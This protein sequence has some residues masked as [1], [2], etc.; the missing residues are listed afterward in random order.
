MASPHPYDDPICNPLACAMGRFNAVLAGHLLMF[1]AAIKQRPGGI[2]AR[3]LLFSLFLAGFLLP[4][5]L[6]VAWENRDLEERLEQDLADRMRAFGALA[7]HAFDTGAPATPS[8]AADIL[9]HVQEMGR[10][11]G[12]A[13]PEHIEFEIRPSVRPDDLGAVAGASQR[14]LM[15]TAVEDLRV[16]LPEDWQPFGRLLWRQAH[17]RMSLP[18]ADSVLG[19]GLLIEVSAAT[20]VEELQRT[21]LH[22]LMILLIIT[23]LAIVLADR[24][25]VLLIRPLQQL[26]EATG[27]LPARII[28]GETVAIASLGLLAEGRALNDAFGVMAK[29]FAESFATLERQR[30]TQTRLRSIRDL[31]AQMLGALM[32]SGED[33]R[34][35]AERL[36]TLLD[37]LLPAYRCSVLRPEVHAALVHFSGVRLGAVE[38]A[39]LE[40]RLSEQDRNGTPGTDAIERL[41]V[42]ESVPGAGGATPSDSGSNDSAA[43]WWCCPVIAQD[44]HCTAVIALGPGTLPAQDAAVPE[45]L[46]TAA[47]LAALAFETLRTRRRHQVLINALSQAGT[48]IVI[49]RRVDTTDYRISYVNQGFETL[50]GYRAEE[51]IGLNSRFLQGAERDQSQ[52]ATIRAALAAGEPC[53][54]TL[55]NYRKDGTQFWNALNLAP[56]IDAQGEVTHYV[57]IQ[58]DLTAMQEAMDGL[59]HSETS[60]R[61][62]QAI[63]HVGSWDLDYRSGRF[64]WSDEAFRLLGY[65]PGAVTPSLEA[66]F[67]VVATEDVALV[68]AEMQAALTRSDGHLL[69]EHRVQ[70]PDGVMR[71]LR[72]QGHAYFA[73]DA[74]PLRLSGT[75]LD[76]TA[77]RV[78]EQ[79][80]RG[81]QERYRLVVENIEDLVVRT[82]GLGRCEYVSPSFCRLFA[83]QE[84]ELIGRRFMPRIHPDDHATT[85]QVIEALHHPPYTCQTEHRVGTEHGWRWLQWIARAVPD[86]AGRIDSIVAIGRDITERKTAESAL[87]EERRRLADI[88]D[89]TLVGTWEWDLLT[90]DLTLNQRW[91]EM[92]GHRLE[93]LLPSSIETWRMFC[94]PDDLAE[95]EAAIARHLDG[96]TAHYRH[97]LRMRHHDG[98]W[99]W[100]RG[101]GHVSARNASGRP[102]RMA[103]THEEITNRKVA[104]LELIQR[105]ALE[106]ELLELASAFIGVYDEALDA[107]VNQTLER[108]GGFTQSDRAYVFRFALDTDRMRNSHEW[109]AAG[110]EP[111]IEHLQDLAIDHYSASMQHLESGQAAVIPR[112]AELPETWA[113]ERELLQFQSV[114]SLV[115]VPCSRMRV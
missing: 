48:G 50:T 30:D 9:A 21:A 55:R 12:G 110:I 106:R 74:T 33:E 14:R 63:A 101:Q 99:V 37:G 70:G 17:Y 52:R 18:L 98:H 13:L 39:A 58:Q 16:L 65:A 102:L 87:A 113:T 47:D 36:C 1:V 19:E 73:A 2:S 67:A 84:A 66:F 64:L 107:L 82:D 27:D 41:L 10:L 53:E 93:D 90:N 28:A 91:A 5:I 51:V 80:L 45:L 94:H 44:G 31:Q 35:T 81:Q 32:A 25:A 15:Q 59:A 68:R 72:Q 11:F 105:E 71:I 103:G 104:E 89:G 97:E 79:A 6:V 78:V 96:E 3:W 88:I 61:E 43:C 57:G 20:L 34:T 100:V 54:V 46:A 38:H 86:A 62:T 83:R 92:L 111:M 112:V 76:I 7:I 85:Q 95:S 69:V 115:L 40:R 60:L 22:L 4:S 24:L 23:V 77:Q 56:L 49:A 42:V 75:S 108:L 109:V 8:E 29:G 26:V 114:L